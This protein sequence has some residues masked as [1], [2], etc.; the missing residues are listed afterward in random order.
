MCCVTK[1]HG[2]AQ[3]ATSGAPLSALAA[4]GAVAAAAVASSRPGDSSSWGFLANS[5]L[6]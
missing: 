1:S 4:G 2:Q 6:P 3:P 5:R